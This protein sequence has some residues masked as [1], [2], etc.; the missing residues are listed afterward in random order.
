MTQGLWAEDAGPTQGARYID[1]SAHLHKAV[2]DIQAGDT[3]ELWDAAANTMSLGL[4]AASAIGDPFGRLVLTPFWGFVM[5]HV[6]PLR[7]L[8]NS[9][10]GDPTAIKAA[11]QYWHTRSE[12][13]HLTADDVRR[14]VQDDTQAWKGIAGDAYRFAGE[15]FANF[16]D[17]LG[18]GATGV[19]AAIHGAGVLAA[20]ARAMIRD[21][22]ADLL[23]EITRAL[24]VAVGMS[25]VTFGA[26]L[27]TAVAWVS[28][29][30]SACVAKCLGWLSKLVSALGR[31]LSKLRNLRGCM[32]D[33]AKRAT[34][35]AAKSANKLD[36]AAA[37]VGSKDFGHVE[38]AINGSRFNKARSSSGFDLKPD[39]GAIVFN[40]NLAGDVVKA[41]NTGNR[42]AA[43]VDNE[44]EKQRA[45]AEQ[46]AQKSLHGDQRN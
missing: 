24:L 43:K 27:G 46:A 34:D 6:Q 44:W 25:W 5:E 9:C 11:S 32:D 10:T 14:R 19:A 28:A 40:P 26:S 4:E 31:Q 22:I 29:K 17:G 2:Q 41:A 30:V 36:G 45:H 23:T 1:Y 20:V 38:R 3:G 15:Q 21:L 37:R 7:E 35:L 18:A 8:L 12:E 33:V 16:I 39:E 13:L 42:E